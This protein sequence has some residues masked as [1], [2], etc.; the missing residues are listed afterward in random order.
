MVTLTSSMPRRSFLRG[1]GTVISLPVLSAMVPALSSFGGNANGTRRV[2]FVYVPHGMVMTDRVDLWTPATI[3]KDFTFSPTLE[4]LQRYRDKVTVISNLTGAIGAG[5]H[6]GA[7]TV[8]LTDAFP[9]AQCTSA[10]QLDIDSG[11]SI[12][13]VIAREIGRDSQIPSLQLGIE[14]TSSLIGLWHTGYSC[15]YLGTISWA[16]PTEPLKMR[17]NPREVFEQMFSAGTNPEQRLERLQRNRSVLDDVSVEAGVLTRRLGAL[18]QATVR[19]YLSNIREV[20]SRIARAEAAMKAGES[21]AYSERVGLMFDLVHLAYQADMTRVFSFMMAREISHLS[22]PEIGVQEPHHALSH[23]QNSPETM[24]KLAQV[25]RYHAQLFADFVAKLAATPDGDGSLLDHTLLMYGS[26]MS[27][28][29]EDSKSRLPIAL[30]GGLT[31]GN[32]HIR[33][34]DDT[35]IGDLHVDLARQT[36]VHLERFGQRSTGGTVGLS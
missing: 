15:D 13:Q 2:G 33:M 14:D 5:Q 31:Q 4:P 7:A 27:N 29:N 19:S 28:G 3:G 26:G 11:A 9:K 32:R 6:S 23:H 18:D 17:K 20:E 10:P 30:V 25:N 34:R 35:P 1:A 12:D 22:Y 8:W 21:V 36:G 24:A 16:S